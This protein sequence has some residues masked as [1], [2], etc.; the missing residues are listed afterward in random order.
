MIRIMDYSIVCAIAIYVVSVTPAY[1][2]LNQ[3]KIEFLQN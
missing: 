2:K 3:T 1:V